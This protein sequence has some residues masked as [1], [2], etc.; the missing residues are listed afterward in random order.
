MLERGVLPVVPAKGSVGSSG[1]LAP[2]AHVAL[3]LVGEGEAE[4]DGERLEGAAALRARGPRARGPRAQGGPRAHQRHAPDGR[5][6]RP[7]GARRAAAARSG[8]SWPWRSRSRRSRA[9]PC[10][11]TSAWP[12]CAR[13]R[14]R[15]ASPPACARCSTAARWWPAT[16]TAGACRTPTRCAARRRCWAPSTTRWATS[17][18][19]SSA[20]CDAV[21]DNPL[22][23]PEDGDVVAGGNFHGQPLSLPLDHLALALCELASFSE[24]RTYALLSPSYAG[25]PAFLSPRPGAVVG[26]HDH[27]VRGGRAGQRVPGA[28]A[29]GRRGLDPDARRARR[30]STRWARSRRSRRARWS[31]TARR[32]SPPSSCAPARASSS[33]A[34]CAPRRRS[35]RAVEKVRALVPRIEEDR[36]ISGELAALAQALRTG[37]VVL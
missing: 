4:V 9:R 35:R 22:V 37:E 29:P 24:R 32:S 15:S 2:L 13:I 26:A 25:L 36:A 23:F 27:A 14:A 3:V 31:R 8:G 28:R 34:R 16:P 7:R 12:A 18:P 6:R 11:S 5:R 30:T 17:R 1:D 20:S 19:R 21:T 33:T 10:P